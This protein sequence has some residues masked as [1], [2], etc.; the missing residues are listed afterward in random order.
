MN[1]EKYK[2]YGTEKFYLNDF[3]TKDT[4]GF[5][6]S[7]SVKNIIEQ[8]IVEISSLQSMFYA[9]GKIALLII[10]QAMDAA[11]KD[12]A[13]NSWYIIP[14]DKKWF[15]Q[16]I[17]LNIL[18]YMM[19]EFNPEYPVITRLQEMMLEESKYKLTEQ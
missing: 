10:F 18:L 15:S 6:S 14:A 2:V 5:D 7:E 11:G 9:D 19:K 12:S 3:D 17:D 1:I 13:T 4:A 16:A 8:N